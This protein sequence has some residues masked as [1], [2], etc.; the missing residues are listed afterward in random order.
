[1]IFLFQLPFKD[2]LCFFEVLQFL[3]YDPNNALLA[4]ISLI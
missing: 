3:T 4:S 2:K 1:M